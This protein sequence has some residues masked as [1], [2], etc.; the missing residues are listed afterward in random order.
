M[1]KQLVLFRTNSTQN[2]FPHGANANCFVL[3]SRNKRDTSQIF[4]TLIGILA[5]S[6]ILVSIIV[7]LSNFLCLSKSMKSNPGPLKL[8]L[9]WLVWCHDPFTYLIFTQQIN[10]MIQCSLMWRHFRI[11]GTNLTEQSH[12]TWSQWSTDKRLTP[13]WNDSL[14]D[15][16]TN[17]AK[18]FLLSA[19]SNTM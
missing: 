5:A 8:Q 13:N 15:N 16:Q 4:Y 7:V 17:L 1:H 18:H 12:I 9:A 14:E 11:Q 10:Q 19:F 2:R 3:L 6:L